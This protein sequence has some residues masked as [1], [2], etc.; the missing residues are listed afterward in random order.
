MNP[1]SRREPS[2]E[3]RFP[4]RAGYSSPSSVP[5]ARPQGP[6]K[7]RSLIT[8]ATQTILPAR[9][10]ITAASA[11]LDQCAR[12]V[13]E[14]D[15]HAYARTSGVIAGS[16][17]GQHVRHALDHF[18]AA[19]SGNAERPIDY[20][21][22]DR[23]TPV[24]RDRHAALAA[25]DGLCARLGALKGHDADTIVRVRVMLASSGQCAELSSTLAR[26]LAFATHH[27]IHHHAMIAAIA[28]ESGLSVPPGFDRAPSTLHHEHHA[29]AP[30][31]PR[32]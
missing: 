27:A 22:R 9:S 4:A 21:H 18:A 24:E 2:R 1:R 15:D 31:G 32:G 16:T 25:I 17:I 20:D 30:G 26:E 5:S 6:V 28:R 3:E 29:A 7:G 11:L 10:T 19:L 12:F 23:D 13:R 8:H 14:L